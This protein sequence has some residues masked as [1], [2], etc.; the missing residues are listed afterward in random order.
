MNNDRP[1]DDFVQRHHLDPEDAEVTSAIR[2]LAAS[3]KGAQ[4][5]IEA[6]TQF[7]ALMESVEPRADVSFQ[8]DTVGGISGLWVHPPEPRAGAEI[9]HLHGGWFNFGTASAFRHFVGQIVARVKTSAFIADYRL[10]PENPFPAATEDV[11]ACY[12]GLTLQAHRRIALTGD[13]AGGNLALGLASRVITARPGNAS[14]LVAVAVFSPV[15]DLTLSGETYRTR[16]AADPFFTRSQVAQLVDSYLG[17]AD[18]RDALASPLYGRLAGLPP[19]CIQVGDDEVLLD[20][21]Q[22]LLEQA[23]R[24]G[25]D[26]RLDLWMGMPHGFV[27]NV[28]KLRAAGLALDVVSAFLSEKLND[29]AIPR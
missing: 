16:A 15:T 28:G 24:A 6:R 3:A 5:G 8:R 13:S 10:A 21:S 22:R 4:R 11:F 20:D 7:D 27:I 25:V 26:A 14:P 12:R 17:A 23:I 2:A 19:T 29:P 9:L 18:P 1:L